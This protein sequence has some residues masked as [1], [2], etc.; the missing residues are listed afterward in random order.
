M[1][2]SETYSHPSVNFHKFAFDFKKASSFRGKSLL[3]VSSVGIKKGLTES[4][5][6]EDQVYQKISLIT[7]PLWKQVCIEFVHMMGPFPALKIYNSRL[8]LLSSQHRI[9]CI[10]CET[11]EESEFLRKYSFVVLGS[12]QK[13][14]P[15]VRQLK[16]NFHRLK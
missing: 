2:R 4:K 8:G 13:Y 12:L 3:P 9:I 1:H 15:A 14:F 16:I 7:D 5:L 10:Y 11:E 6:S